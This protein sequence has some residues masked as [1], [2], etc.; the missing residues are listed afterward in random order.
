MKKEI[1]KMKPTIILIIVLSIILIIISILNKK[2]YNNYYKVVNR[3]KNIIEEKKK[4][5]K[6]KNYS[7]IGWVKVQGTKVDTPIVDVSVKNLGDIEKTDFAYTIDFKNR[8]RNIIWGHNILNLS[9]HPLIG[10]KYFTRFEDLMQLIYIRKAKDIKY[11]QVTLEGKTKLYKIYAVGF[12]GAREEQESILYEENKDVEEYVKSSIER[13]IY[14]YNVDIKENDN[15]ITLITCTRLEGYAD[16][17]FVINAREV[18]KKEGI[19]NYHV[20]ETSNYE[21]IKKVL[22]KGETHEKEGI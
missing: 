10:E 7:T 2:I 14:K 6:D 3:D 12:N 13:S 18:R 15:L 9:S 1:M 19:N 20:E 11:I 21:A 8:R 5:K 22:E 16:K 17:E 4:D